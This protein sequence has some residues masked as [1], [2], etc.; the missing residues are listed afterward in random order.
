MPSKRELIVGLVGILLGTGATIAG[1]KTDAL[2]LCG[3][4]E[5]GVTVGEKVLPLVAKAL[6]AGA[7]AAP[8]DAGTAKPA[9]D[10]GK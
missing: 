6:D 7:L 9:Q 4:V 2:K 8:V 10:A 3:G 5:Q 1:V